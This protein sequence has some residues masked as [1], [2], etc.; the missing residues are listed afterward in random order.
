LSAAPRHSVLRNPERVAGTVV[1]GG[2]PCRRHG[3]IDRRYEAHARHDRSNVFFVPVGRWSHVM[4]CQWSVRPSGVMPLRMARAT[5][6]SDHAPIPVRDTVC[7]WTPSV[8]QHAPLTPNGIPTSSRDP[9][10]APGL[11]FAESVVVKDD[12]TRF[13]RSLRHHRVSRLGWLCLWLVA[14]HGMGVWLS[15]PHSSAK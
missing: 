2:R 13:L 12:R 8:Q 4:P 11:A 15:A 10:K 1:R 5:C 3:M 7:E 9:E 6:G 14:K